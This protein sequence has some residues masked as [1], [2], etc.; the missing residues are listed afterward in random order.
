M[1]I[2]HLNQQLVQQVLLELAE[3][4]ENSVIR[5]K[6]V[7]QNKDH[8]LLKMGSQEIEASLEGE[9]ENLEGKNIRFLVKSNEDSRIVLKP[10]LDESQIKT[11]EAKNENTVEA[12]LKRLNLPQDKS[13]QELIKNMMKFGLPID[14]KSFEEAFSQLNKMESLFNLKEGEKVFVNKDIPMGKLIDNAANEAIKTALKDPNS[15]LAKTLNQIGNTSAKESEILN[16]LK[17][18]KS[19]EEAQ[20]KLNMLFT[21]KDTSLPKEN[22]TLNSRESLTMPNKENL[23]KSNIDNLIVS[24]GD[25]QGKEEVTREVKS[26]FEGLKPN[27]PE[28][29]PKLVSFFKKMDI[30]LNSENIKSMVEYIEKPELFIKELKTFNE[31]LKN[32]PELQELVKREKGEDVSNLI[33]KLAKSLDDSE[34]SKIFRSQLRDGPVE[35]LSQK[36]NFMNDMN[37]NMNFMMFPLNEQFFQKEGMINLIKDGKGR[38]VDYKKDVNIMINVETNNLGK[39][40]VTCRLSNKKLIVRLN[41]KKEDIHMFKKESDELI[42]KIEDLGYEVGEIE[43]T[44]DK[45]PSILDLQVENERPNFYLDLRI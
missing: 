37:R 4:T 14:E 23:I 20:Q 9:I 18:S 22:L 34:M 44:Y 19:P 33:N 31:V 15:E 40:K 2:D 3:L 43:F 12:L 30:P 8:I 36:M 21:E 28:T 39:V 29:L 25:L 35:S 16:I 42:K 38:K 27:D 17:N 41:V 6:V 26:F 13:S 5:G 1:R 45:E 7:E 32:S 10:L 11:A 24:K